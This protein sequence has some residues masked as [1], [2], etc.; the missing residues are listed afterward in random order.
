MNKK[1]MAVFPLFLFI[2][3][4]FFI[5]LFLGIGLFIFNQVNDVFDQDVDV[6]KVNLQDINNLTFGKMNTGFIDNADLIG[7]MLL[8][9][10][11]V[12][13]I[14]NGFFIGSKYPKLF[15]VID[16]LILVFIFIASV[17]ISQI[18]ETFIN[19]TVILDLYINDLPHTSTFVLNLPLIIGTLGAL[20]M[21]FSYSGIARQKGGEP[22]VSGF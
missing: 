9:M 3:A 11:S 1:A 15:M 22:N 20:I 14:M 2:F 21:V 12:L 6:G 18:Y 4:V 16:I 17:Y 13:M 5:A 10:M 8:L 19:S 7:I